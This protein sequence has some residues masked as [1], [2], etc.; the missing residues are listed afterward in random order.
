[1]TDDSRRAMTVAAI[2]KG[3]RSRPIGRRAAGPDSPTAANT[4]NQV[5]RALGRLTNNP[6]SA[7]TALPATYREAGAHRLTLYGD[8]NLPPSRTMGYP[9][10]WGGRQIIPL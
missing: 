8:S 9:G 10:L 4:G 1:M 2:P 6:A 7:D 3:T 5:L